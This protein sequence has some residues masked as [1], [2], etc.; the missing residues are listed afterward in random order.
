M[1][2]KS[3]ESFVDKMDAF[4]DFLKEIGQEKKLLPILNT[5]AIDSSN[6]LYQKNIVLTGLRDKD[7]MDQL[8]KAGANIASAVSKNTFLVIAKTKEDTGKV[9]DANKLGIPIFTVEEFMDK[10]F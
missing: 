10:Y 1:A 8:K 3:A 5:N 7:L 2:I 6:P 4:K 9:L